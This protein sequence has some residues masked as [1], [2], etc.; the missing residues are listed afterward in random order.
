MIFLFF[1]FIVKKMLLLIKPFFR[2]IQMAE[3]NSRPTFDSIQSVVNAV[4][5]VAMMLENT[6]FALT[7]SF[8]AILG[9]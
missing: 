2:F 7:S 1:Y 3:E 6:F 4:G 8:R 9:E 5:S